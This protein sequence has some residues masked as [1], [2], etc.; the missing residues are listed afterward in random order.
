MIC[1]HRYLL[2]ELNRYRYR[3]AITLISSYPQLSKRPSFNLLDSLLKRCVSF[4]YIHSF[5]KGHMKTHKI[6]VIQSSYSQ[7]FTHPSNNMVQ[8]CLTSG[9]RRELLIS[10][11][12]GLRWYKQAMPSLHQKSDIA[13]KESCSINVRKAC[14]AALLT[15]PRS[16]TLVTVV[17]LSI[18][19]PTTELSTYVLPHILT[20]NTGGG[21][22]Y[23]TNKKVNIYAGELENESAYDTMYS[24]AVTHPSTN[25]AQC[26]LTSVIRREL[27]FS[28]WYGRRRYRYTKYRYR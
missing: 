4:V 11:R 19:W 8:F 16:T 1:I 26:C 14:F 13:D 6:F 18:C 22:L 10:T 7:V 23:R 28:T 12:Y 5:L 21:S 24:Q 15:S 2:L 20:Y 9:I 25:M 3:Y 17:P 27:V